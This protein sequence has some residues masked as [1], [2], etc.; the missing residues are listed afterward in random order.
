MK[1]TQQIKETTFGMSSK[2]VIRLNVDTDNSIQNQCDDSLHTK[3]MLEPI[4]EMVD[5]PKHSKKK[6]II[7]TKITVITCQYLGTI[8]I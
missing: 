7:L 4:F 1:D 8:K 5:F 6:L 2:S 3:S